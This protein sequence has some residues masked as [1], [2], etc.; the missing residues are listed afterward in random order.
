AVLAHGLDTVAPTRNR[1]L[2]EQILTSG[3]VLLSEHPPGVPP[4]P[5]EFVRRNRIQSGLSIASI[6]VE[7]GREGGAIHQARFTIAHGRTLF[8]VLPPP[9][10][11]AKYNYNA[12]GAH[13]LLDRMSALQLSSYQD[14]AEALR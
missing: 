14:L 10:L 8:A 11:I 2:A 13:L 9:G 5:A 12:E 4:R 1:P 7:S 3:G 6:V